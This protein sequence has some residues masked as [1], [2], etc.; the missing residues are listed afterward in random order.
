ML[1]EISSTKTTP[2]SRC[3]APLGERMASGLIGFRGA[4]GGV[5]EADAT[6]TAARLEGGGGVP[7]ATGGADREGAL[8]LLRMTIGIVSVFPVE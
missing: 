3:G 2:P 8:S 6:G 1:P 5:L 7:V 4:G